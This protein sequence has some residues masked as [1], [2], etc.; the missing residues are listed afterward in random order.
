MSGPGLP[1]RAARIKCACADLWAHPIAQLL[2]GPT[3]HPGGRRLTAD[4]V[5]ALALRPRARV[6]DIGSGTGATLAE[7]TRRGF[8]ACGIDYSNIL[9]A[10][11]IEHAPVTVGDAEALPHTAGSF[12]AVLAEC[13]FSALPDKPTALAEARRVL[14]PQGR[15]LLSD[16]TV[17]GE[18]P[19]PLRSVAA[20]AACV[21]G[22]LSY[23]GY[24]TQLRAHGFTTTSRE[25]ASDALKDLVN[26]AER[27]LAMLQGAM[28]A[29][30]LEDATALFGRELEWLG[31]PSSREALSTLASV[32]FAQTRDAIDRGELGYATF[33][34]VRT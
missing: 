7:L 32:L 18:L 9:A 16:V 11:A 27:R 13:V 12:D 17:N 33:I 26:Q 10:Q 23:E 24:E 3:L 4:L 29:G 14:V 22:A 8:R 20:W 30:V 19:E 15:I 1:D 2:A 6:L 21:G 28:A 31:V 25:D 5:D 34:A